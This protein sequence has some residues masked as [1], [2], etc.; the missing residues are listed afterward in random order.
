M[1]ITTRSRLDLRAVRQVIAKVS[2]LPDDKVIDGNDEIDVSAW[3]YFISVNQVTSETI[4]T[5]IKFDSKTETETVTTTR[6]TVISINAFGKNAY[7]LLETFETSL[8]T[9]FAQQLF[10]DIGAGIV[11][12]SPIRNLP[13]AIAGGK[14]HR[15]QI[16]LTL[17]HNHRIETPLNRGESVTISIK[18]D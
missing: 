14:E 11:R 5:E 13:T 18:K 1:A 4:G 17:S 15:A 10:K 3:A 12:Q 9:A 7:Q 2:Q 6:E 8:S 16:D